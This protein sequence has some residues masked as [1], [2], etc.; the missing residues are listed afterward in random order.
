MVGKSYLPGFKIEAQ[1]GGEEGRACVM[2][3]PSTGG[4]P[5][6]PTR[7]CWNAHPRYLWMDLIWKSGLYNRDH[8]KMIPYRIRMSP[9]A[10]TNVLIRRQPCKDTDGWQSHDNRYWRAGSCNSRN[11]RDRWQRA[12]AVTGGGEEG[13][14]RKPPERPRFCW[15]SARRP[16][17][18]RT[19][20]Y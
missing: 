14:F 5:L 6:S 11:A 9:K 15:P 2:S 3:R 8:I 19:M 7:M 17:A 20:R 1:G 4:W 10:R 18:S 12:E 13:L 16:P